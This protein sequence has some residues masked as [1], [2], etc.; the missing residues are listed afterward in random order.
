[1]RRL[2]LLLLLVVSLPIAMQANS[3]P[4]VFG[5]TGGSLSTNGSTISLQNSTLTSFSGLGFNLT[6]SLGKVKFT[7]GALTG[8]NLG[9]AGTFAAGG[10]FAITSNGTGG[11]P[12]GVLFHGTFSGPVNWVGSFNALGNGGLGAWTY[13]L[14]GQVQGTFFNGQTASGGTVQFSFDVP[15]GFEFGIGHPARGKSGTTTVTAVPEPG[16]LALLGTG[17]FAFGSL[18]RRKYP[19]T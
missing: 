7:T 8:G 4:I 17:L 2:F 3:T 11:L 16:S 19:T 18:V 14:T 12:A 10:P 5:N 13:T 15:K 6:G 1:M 9:V